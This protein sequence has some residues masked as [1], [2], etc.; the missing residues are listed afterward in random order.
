MAKTTSRDPA[1]IC[2]ERIAALHFLHHVPVEPSSN[3]VTK[4]QSRSAGY[5]LPFEKERDLAGTLAF[6]A[7]HK[8]DVNHIPA[9]CIE[10]GPDATYINVLLAINK[11]EYDEGRQILEELKNWFDE[12]FSL[13]DQDYAS[14]SHIEND[15]FKVIISMCRVRILHRLR[16]E[17]RLAQK[18]SIKNALQ[19]AFDYF[20]HEG[21][22]NIIKSKKL[23]PTLKRFIERA[24]EVLRLTDSWI[25]HRT[26]LELEELVEGIRRLRQVESLEALIENIPDNIM[27]PNLRDSLLNM[28]SKVARYREAARFLYRISKKI[29]LARK[30]R[31][32]IVQWPQ[33]AFAKSTK[34]INSQ[35]APNLN[36]TVSLIEGLKNRER[37]LADICRLLNS[38][39]K[40]ESRKLTREEAS[41]RFAAQARRTLREA[42]IHAEIQL[43]Y[44]CELNIPHSR[45]PRVVCSSKDACWLCNEF[46]LLY[47]KMH[48]PS[49]HGRIYPGWR[50][51]ALRDDDLARRYNQ[52]LQ[53]SLRS[54]LKTLF[55]RRKRTVYPYPNESTL[56]ALDLSDSTL[57]SVSLPLD[58]G[59]GKG[60]REVVRELVLEAEGL[61]TGDLALA[62]GVEGKEDVAKVEEVEEVK[63]VYEIEVGKGVQEIKGVEDVRDEEGRGLRVKEVE[64]V[65]NMNNLGEEEVREDEA[66]ESQN[67]KET[68]E[69]RKEV[70]EVQNGE[71]VEETTPTAATAN[72]EV[73][74]NF[75]ERWSSGCS[76]SSSEGNLTLELGEVKSKKI[77]MGRSTPLYKAASLLDIQ[78]KYAKSTSSDTP[79]NLHK[80][81][82]YSLER[83]GP[84]DVAKLQDRGVVPIASAGLPSHWVED[85]T[86][87]EGCIYIT[88][89]NAVVKLSLRPI[90][91]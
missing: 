29:P 55:A 28:I 89:G 79:D 62:R 54:S 14:S 84:E 78:V 20:R 32:V 40:A 72:G 39:E 90:L 91:E 41:D 13:L 75:S 74:G 12:I 48:T 68:E 85:S 4:V 10:E 76:S 17:G 3:P 30:M 9:L 33:N 64:Q 25:N 46:I 50:L 18:Q 37:N 88:N 44:Y 86:D 38:D 63:K 56:L 6:L 15:V 5:T 83:L 66:Q 42:K 73:T 80:K 21:R 43:L 49:S 52:R 47:E 27:H 24:R 87:E 36:T 34:S 51:P 11:F 82:S 77:W 59:K 7:Y 65:R 57:S 1:I 53:G 81:L 26:D 69:A 22:G 60:V 8:V 67:V 2:A 23:L 45:L 35:Y 31:A 16:L 58:D 71:E 61:S 19:T 70:G